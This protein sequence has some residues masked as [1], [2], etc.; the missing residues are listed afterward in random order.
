MKVLVIAAHGS[1]KQASNIEVE[2][3]AQRL[4]AKLEGRF[5]Q[6]VHAFL[7]IADPLLKST[8]DHLAQTG[9]SQIVVFPF[10][11]GAGSHIA[12]DIPDLVKTAG[13]TYPDVQFSLTRH[14]GAIESIET[15]IIDEVSPL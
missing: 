11:I 13:Q 1:R 4:A 7:Q 15:I 6:V 12:E 9:A 5:D 3:L 8:L 10:F 2:Q 14:L